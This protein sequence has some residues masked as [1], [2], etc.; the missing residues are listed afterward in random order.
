[1]NTLAGTLSTAGGTAVVTT[2]VGTVPVADAGT[3]VDGA[4]VVAGVRPE[5]LHVGSGDRTVTG[6]VENVELLGHERHLLVDAEGTILVVRQSND[7]V[8]VKVGDRIDLAAEADEVHLF[9]PDSTE[10]LN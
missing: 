3:A 5:H 9:D 2:P 4:R 10:R 6:V 1:M 7:D 8:E